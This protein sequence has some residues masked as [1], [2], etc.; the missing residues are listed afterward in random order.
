MG[1]YGEVRLATRNSRS[2]KEK[3]KMTAPRIGLLVLAVAMLLAPVALNAGQPDNNI[4]KGAFIPDHNPNVLVES[5][6]P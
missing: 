4:S 1:T 6:T 5:R 3:Q 2:E